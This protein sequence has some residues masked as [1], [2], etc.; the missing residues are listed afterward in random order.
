MNAPWFKRIGGFHVPASV[1]GAMPCSLA[2]LLCAGLAGLH[3]AE[4]F[5]EVAYDL[6]M[7]AFRS[8]D[9]AAEAR[10]K[11]RTNSVVCV[12][13][14]TLWQIEHD[15]AQNGPTRCFFDGTNVYMS[16]QITRPMSAEE[17][18]RYEKAG[19]LGQ[20]LATAESDPSSVTIHV[21]PST[22][23]HPMG[24]VCENI[25]WLAF[26]SGPFLQRPGRLIPLPA[27][28]LRHTRDRYGYTDKTTLFDEPPG[29]PRAVDLYTSRALFLVS[30]NDFD[31]EANFGDRY[32]ESTKKRAAHL[33]EGVLTFRYAVTE[34]TNVFG[35][36]LPIRFEFFQKGRSYEQNGDWTWRGVGRVKSIRPVPQPGGLFDP[37]I[38]QTVVDWRFKDPAVGLDAIIYTTTNTFLAPT[39][40]LVLQQK[41]RADQQR[42]RDHWKP[43]PSPYEATP[44]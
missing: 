3:A 31:K 4:T 26:C 5:V 20:V 2:G 23:G 42:F 9:P 15:Q 44:K 10:A 1:P 11:P 19:V 21:W 6:E 35:R 34:S 7:V 8:D 30:E 32:T 16:L 12:T 14:S 38:Q 36:R 33:E 25:A 29:L 40:D 41:F 27:D 37:T 22:D 17:K 43:V 13:G 39:N 18:A 24:S 28:D